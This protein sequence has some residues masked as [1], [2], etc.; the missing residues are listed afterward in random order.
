MCL[1]DADTRG[2]GKLRLNKRD[3]LG[4]EGAA[5]P[6][7]GSRIPGGNIEQSVGEEV[8]KPTRPSKL[9]LQCRNEA[10]ARRHLL[11]LLVQFDRCC[12]T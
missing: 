12:S 7:K 11:S 9:G 10:D 8:A 5:V 1:L 3:P 4:P 2:L 6:K